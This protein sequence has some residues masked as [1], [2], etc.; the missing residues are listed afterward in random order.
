M[1]AFGSFQSISNRSIAALRH[2]NVRSTFHIA[3]QYFTRRKAN[4]TF[5]KGK[6]HR[7]VQK[8]LS[9]PPDYY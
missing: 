9:E 6:F 7:A 4:F 1:Q 5:L 8:F 2:N 3:K